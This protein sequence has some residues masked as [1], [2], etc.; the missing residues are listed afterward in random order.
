MRN[1]AVASMNFFDNNLKI[2]FVKAENWKSALGQVEDLS[3]YEL[4]DD[5]EE[6]KAEAFNGDWVF[7]V[8]EL[9][10]VPDDSKRPEDFIRENNTAFARGD[11]GG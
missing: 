8:K 6:A 3:N 2:T 7:D 9:P 1:F 5:L 11:M 4:P 10:Y